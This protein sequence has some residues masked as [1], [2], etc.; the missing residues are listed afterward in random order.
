MSP[1]RF[2]PSLIHTCLA[3]GALL[4]V[5]ATAQADVSVTLTA[6]A[7]TTQLPDGQTVPMWGLMCGTGTAASSA[8]T[9]LT[10]AVQSGTGWQPPLITVPQGQVLNIN[11]INSLSFNG[12]SI[13]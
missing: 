3:A 1:R 5:Q 2:K 8:C 9:T 13:P 12:N 6:T 11:L 4:F 7:T 10:G